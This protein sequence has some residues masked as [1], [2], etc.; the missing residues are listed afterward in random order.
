MWPLLPNPQRTQGHQL[1]RLLQ[2]PRSSQIPT[3]PLFSDTDSFCTT[4]A[5][6]RGVSF[7]FSRKIR[8]GNNFYVI[9]VLQHFSMSVILISFS[10]L[11]QEIS[12]IWTSFHKSHL[13]EREFRQPTN[14]PIRIHHWSLHVEPRIDD[15]AS[16]V[17]PQV[18][19]WD[20]Q[21]RF[22]VEYEWWF[23]TVRQRSW[24]QKLSSS[25]T[26]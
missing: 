26:L 9:I 4:Q 23:P 3:G 19:K 18:P 10:K 1:Q 12:G 6:A 13:W 21:N 7:W 17:P 15:H 24:A 22:Q 11:Y 14:Q 5:L 20:L 25:P 2:H 16:F 8:L